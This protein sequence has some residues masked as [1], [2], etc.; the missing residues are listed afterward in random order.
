MGI[1]GSLGLLFIAG[2]GGMYVPKHAF[3]THEENVKEKSKEEKSYFSS[4]KARF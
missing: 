1:L 2:S 4:L 3:A